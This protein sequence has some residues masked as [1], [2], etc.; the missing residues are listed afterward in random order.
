[1]YRCA[2][3]DASTHGRTVW[4]LGPTRG[5]NIR[6]AEK[7]ETREKQAGH[8]AGPCI[9][10][11]H[12]YMRLHAHALPRPSASVCVCVCVHKFVCACPFTCTRFTISVFAR[13]CCQGRLFFSCAQRIAC[14]LIRYLLNHFLPSSF[15]VPSH[16]QSFAHSIVGCRSFFVDVVCVVLFVIFFFFSL[17]AA[18]RSFAISIFFSH[19]CSAGRIGGV[20]L[21]RCY[22][23]Q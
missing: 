18:F 3:L 6:Y 11:I 20:C 9:P 2:Y 13:R 12:T 22:C 15:H 8:T 10:Y 4:A 7:H 5:N 17:F 21:S 16:S 1:M 14:A 23:L 19:F